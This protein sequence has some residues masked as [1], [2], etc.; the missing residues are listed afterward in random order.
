MSHCHPRVFTFT[1]TPRFLGS[2]HP[3]SFTIH[4][5]IC[6]CFG[7]LILP[8]SVD[9]TVGYVRTSFPERSLLLSVYGCL[10]FYYQPSYPS[11][12]TLQIPHTA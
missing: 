10:I 1:S 12:V 11:L 2:F 6:R 3:E 5:H 9:I 8:L 4:M 7:F